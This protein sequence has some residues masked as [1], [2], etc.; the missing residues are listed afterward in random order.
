MNEIHS[1]TENRSSQRRDAEGAE[2]PI[3][4]ALASQRRPRPPFD[5]LRPSRAMS[6]GVAHE[7]DKRLENAGKSHIRRVAAPGAMLISMPS[8]P[9]V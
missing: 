1:W 7:V 9:H 2:L 6:R 8:E 5:E 3:D 4:F